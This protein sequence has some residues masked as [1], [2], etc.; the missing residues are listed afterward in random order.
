MTNDIRWEQ[1][2]YNFK[3]ALIQLQHAVDLSSSRELSHLE[4]QGLVQGF[5]YT[6]ELAWKTLKDFLEYRGATEKIYGSKDSVR[7]AFKFDLITAGDD[8]MGMI[9]SRNLTSHTYNEDVVFQIVDQ[10]LNIYIHR[11]NELNK[12][13]T[14]ILNEK[15]L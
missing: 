5:E 7:E 10:I 12:K 8:W 6:H 4:K 3:K 1:R 11:F 2:F 9:K 15:D 13:L 14:D